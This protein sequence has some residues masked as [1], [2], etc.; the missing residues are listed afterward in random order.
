VDEEGRKKFILNKTEE[1]KFYSRLSGPG[2][3]IDAV[4][5]LN[6]DTRRRTIEVRSEK[7]TAK[8]KGKTHGIASFGRTVPIPGNAY[9]TANGGKGKITLKESGLETFN[10]IQEVK[11]RR[12]AK[13]NKRYIQCLKKP[14][15]VCTQV[16]FML[17]T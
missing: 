15:N 17:D 9:V 11:V 16:P 2:I 7:T 12:M 3:R 14:G 4:A 5:I 6:V 8:K 1:K 13:D 10:R